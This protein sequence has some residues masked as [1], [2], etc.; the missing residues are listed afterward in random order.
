MLQAAKSPVT[1][2]RSSFFL[3]GLL[4]LMPVA[5]RRLA[6]THEPSA[7]PALL[8]AAI[9]VLNVK[10]SPLITRRKNHVSLQWK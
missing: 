2:L 9:V 10:K 6:A 1:F 3:E 8:E 4:P 5:C 7:G